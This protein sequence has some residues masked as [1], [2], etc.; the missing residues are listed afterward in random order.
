[1]R[2]SKGPVID[3][4]QLALSGDLRVRCSQRPVAEAVVTTDQQSC[5]DCVTTDT[6]PLIGPEDDLYPSTSGRCGG[7]WHR[8]TTHRHNKLSYRRG[9]ARC[10]VSV[11]IL[12]LPSNSAE[13][14]GVVCVIQRLAVLVEHRLVT[15]T[16]TDRQTDT[17]PWLVPRMHSIAR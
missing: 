12:Q 6:P 11:E 10:V 17:S 3:L 14:T 15:D 16:D 13:T 1:V 4:I 7:I 9:T 2:R 8:D 5:D